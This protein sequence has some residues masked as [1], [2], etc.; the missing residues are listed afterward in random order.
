[1]STKRIAFEKTVPSTPIISLSALKDSQII[2]IEFKDL[3]YI[4]SSGVRNL[5]KWLKDLEAAYPM[6][7]MRVEKVPPI[8]VRQLLSIK[9]YLPK[10]LEVTSVYVPYFCD[11]CNSEDH[12]LLVNSESV[13]NAASPKE[14]LTESVL[15]K[16]CGQK[17]EPDAVLDKYLGIMLK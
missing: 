17:M 7:I 14:A 15:C 11:G 9:D 4:N 1:M 16:T 13:R 2:E 10:K 5:I 3:D 8:L 6:L 12:S